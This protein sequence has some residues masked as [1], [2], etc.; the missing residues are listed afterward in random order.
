MALTIVLAGA[1]VAL[2]VTNIH[3]YVNK[4]WDFG[5]KCGAMSFVGSALL[6][7]SLLF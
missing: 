5:L 4:K 1:G 3:N 6:G 7:L 2:G